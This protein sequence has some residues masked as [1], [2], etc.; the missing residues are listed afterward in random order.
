MSLSLRILLLLRAA[1]DD[2][3]TPEAQLRTDLRYAVRPVPLGSDFNQAFGDL[4]ERGLAVA[5]RD[6]LDGTVRWKI[7][8]AGR[9]ALAERQL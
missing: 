3:L 8:D 5:V 7:T 1:G 6:K 2:L 9:A 4:D